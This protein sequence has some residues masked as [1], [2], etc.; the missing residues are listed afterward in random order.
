M[1]GPAP[2]FE[3]SWEFLQRFHPGRSVVVTGIGFDKKM[4]PTETF[5][6][7]ERDRFL[8]W[9]GAAARSCNLYF[10]VA[11]PLRPMQKKMERTD[12]ARVW[13]LHVDVDPVKG[14]PIDEER[15]RILATLRDPPGLP[16]PTCITFSGGGYQAYWKL[17]EPII[18]DG[19]ET[20]ADDAALF[21]FAIE[22]AIGG[23]SCSDVSRIMRLPGTVNVPN[24]RK[25]KNGQVEMLAEVVEF[26][27]SRVYGLAQ[28][29]K[30]DQRSRRREGAKEGPELHRGDDAPAFDPANVR[31]IA[32]VDELGEHVGEKCKQCIANGFIPDDPRGV[33]DGSL[34]HFPSRSERLLW[35]CCE[36][37]RAG[38]DDERIY[39]IITDPAYPISASVTERK[40]DA[41]K[42]ALRQISRAKDEAVSPELRELN[43]RHAVIANYGGKCVAV[44]EIT[45]PVIGRA[46]LTTIGFDHFR[47]RYM[48]R[49]VVAGQDKNGNAQEMPLGEWWLRHTHRRQYERVVFAPEMNIPGAYNLW[50]GWAC[51]PK[52][53]EWGLMRQHLLDVVCDGEEKYLNWLL[54]YIAHMVQRPAEP[55]YSAIVLRGRE[56]TGKSI[57]TRN[58]ARW[59]GR[60][61]MSVSQPGHLVGNFNAHLRDCVLLVAEE[62][63]FAGDKRHESVMKALITEPTLMIEKKGM[64]VE[65]SANCTHLFMLSNER[66]VV[67]AGADARR[68][69][70]LDVSDA[71]MGEAA[72]FEKLQAEMDAGG[73]EAWLHDMKTRP[74]G[75]WRPRVPPRTAAL[76][77]QQNHTLEGIDAVWFDVLRSGE[78]PVGQVMPDGTAR[79]P[80]SAFIDW[81]RSKR[82]RHSDRITTSSLVRLLGEP[83]EH[84]RSKRGK[85]KAPTWLGYRKGREWNASRQT[86]GP[87][88]YEVPPL[89]Q[90]RADWDRIRQPNEWDEAASWSLG[91]EA[92]AVEREGGTNG[93][94]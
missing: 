10:H 60:H 7:D 32:H 29:P 92:F 31:R 46:A 1:I 8:S 42:Y 47:N 13:W 37:V 87:W 15:N 50:R 36:L 80:S 2:N 9:V 5:G 48:N 69:F 81:A 73:C 30:A 65:Q 79:V 67:P 68:Y 43:D 70:V 38:I 85:S 24:E 63:F 53:G 16:P 93:I 34:D 62:A 61:A 28:F 72:Y 88:Y 14:K 94:S 64:D 86:S 75:D 84:Q 52:P 77:E 58:M 40:S 90:A 41:H 26:D 44:E 82:Y 19:D 23:D 18:V 89:A 6:P 76:V 78:I 91:E 25:K 71:Q 22:Q 27:E 35:V 49:K 17:H 3:K 83:P 57:V 21:N 59:F 45:E 4:L 39:S 55:G 66:W 12:C 51:E 56:G 20:K 54:D 33:V 11:E 74:I